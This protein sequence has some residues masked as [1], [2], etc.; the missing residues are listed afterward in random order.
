MSGADEVPLPK[1]REIGDAEVVETLFE[2]SGLILEWFP[3]VWVR[4]FS[5][6]TGD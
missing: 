2:I 5:Q 6:K 3:P 4:E 1:F